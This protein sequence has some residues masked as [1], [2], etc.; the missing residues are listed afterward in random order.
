MYRTDARESRYDYRASRNVSICRRSVWNFLNHNY[1]PFEF[2][3]CPWL[4]RYF[5]LF[6][7]G[8]FIDD[9]PCLPDA[10]W[11]EGWKSLP[12]GS[13]EL[14]QAADDRSLLNSIAIK[15]GLRK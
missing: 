7:F 6:W 8:T 5:S 3:P 13:L 10:R 12:G 14:R 11:K 2:H 4:Q 9:S 1:P 15:I